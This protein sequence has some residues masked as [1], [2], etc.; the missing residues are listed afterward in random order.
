MHIYF[1]K[2]SVLWILVYRFYHFNDN[3]KKNNSTNNRTITTTFKTT[4][5]PLQSS[6]LQM[7]ITKESQHNKCVKKIFKLVNI[8]AIMKN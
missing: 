6:L 7:I 4:T 3:N 8:L 5:K 2:L 1:I